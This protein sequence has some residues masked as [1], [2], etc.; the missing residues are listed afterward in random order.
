MATFF[1]SKAY[2][3]HLNVL[4]NELSCEEL[5]ESGLANPFRV[6]EEQIETTDLVEKRTGQKTML[7]PQ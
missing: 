2:R 4:C 1:N 6:E 7:Q 5:I 3:H